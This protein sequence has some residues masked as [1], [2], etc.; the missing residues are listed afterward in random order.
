MSSRDW[1]PGYWDWELEKRQGGIL[2]VALV[3]VMADQ[4]LDRRHHWVSP[5]GW[6]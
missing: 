5:A 4:E 6:G 2:L 3:D 1:R